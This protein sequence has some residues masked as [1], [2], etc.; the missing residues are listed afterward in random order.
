M[1][2]PP[3]PLSELKIPQP[4]DVTL[5][6]LSFSYGGVT[7]FSGL[8][9]T[10]HIGDIIGV[11]G[12]VACVKSTFGRAFLCEAPYGG[13]IRFGKRE[14]IRSVPEYRRLYEAQT[15]GRGTP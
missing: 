13:S 15:G 8:S 5:N 9:L 4:A 11:T 7:V 10:A 2:K 6:N 14:L 3:K 1:L 12:P